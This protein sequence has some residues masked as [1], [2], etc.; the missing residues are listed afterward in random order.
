MLGLKCLDVRLAVDDFGMGYSSLAYLKRF[1][2]D[3]LKV[4]K[5]FVDGL[6][7]HDSRSAAIVGA[8]L[9][10]ASALEL[11]AVAEGVETVEQASDLEAL[12]CPRAQGYYFARPLSPD[13]LD[14]LIGASLP[15]PPH[16][17]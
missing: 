13:S 15:V 1:P 14:G 17:G 16:A 9:D 10:L 3:V 7:R 5:A 8:V 11:T 2:I 12:G 4:D 6:G